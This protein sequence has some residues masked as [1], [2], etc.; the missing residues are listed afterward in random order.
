MW[1][2]NLSASLTGD[3]SENETK[4]CRYHGDFEIPHIHQE[5]SGG[6]PYTF[7]VNNIFPIFS[8]RAE[9][10]NVTSFLMKFCF[11]T[12]QDREHWCSFLL[13]HQFGAAVK[14]QRGWPSHFC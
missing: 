5:Q 4:I 13:K 1:S 2:Y 9:P 12:F 7:L 10:L 14:Q 6:S 3:V 11:N 8:L